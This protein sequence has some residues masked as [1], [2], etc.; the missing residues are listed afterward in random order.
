MR[1]SDNAKSVFPR[2]YII[3]HLENNA[4]IYGQ[5]PPY[6]SAYST[7]S[8]VA[9]RY[10]IHKKSPSPFNNSVSSDNRL[11]EVYESPKIQ[12]ISEIEIKL[13]SPEAGRYQ[14]KKEI[15]YEFHRQIEN[16]K[17]LVSINRESMEETKG[18]M[19]MSELVLEDQIRRRHQQVDRDL[20]VLREEADYGNRVI[21]GDMRSSGFKQS[22]EYRGN[23]IDE[24][25]NRY[26]TPYKDRASEQSRYY[27]Q[28]ENKPPE[29]ELKSSSIFSSYEQKSPENQ[30]QSAR[31]HSN[32][33]NKLH[34]PDLR[35]SRHSLRH[36]N[37]N[38]TELRSSRYLHHYEAKPDL[39]ITVS[40]YSPQ[41]QSFEKSQHSPDIMQEVKLSSIQS[42]S[43]SLHESTR[44]P[45]KRTLP[46]ASPVTP[47]S[48]KIRVK[49]ST[50]SSRTPRIRSSTPK[51]QHINNVYSKYNTK[52]PYAK[53]TFAHE[54]RAMENQKYT[55]ASNVSS[56]PSRERPKHKRRRSHKGACHIRR[57]SR[58][59]MSQLLKVVE[60]HTRCCGDLR[61]EV[62]RLKRDYLPLSSQFRQ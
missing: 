54:V 57:E 60:G 61:S 52:S 16:R 33:E 3:P 25:V 27:G 26:S 30:T 23:Q 59:F 12:D 40:T 6:P 10:E 35:S 24:K 21:E 58:E 29:S 18:R 62:A 51:Y 43:R 11:N 39:D 49:S 15:E 56:T 4:Y 37:P 5:L 42:P 13:E 8:T 20:N 7:P 31:Y 17:E 28:Y 9:S 19:R 53:S 36:N 47:P 2:E 32:H 22:M 55:F 50:R 41:Y 44:S 45:L 14:G 46:L 1:S 34:E 48:H 38:E